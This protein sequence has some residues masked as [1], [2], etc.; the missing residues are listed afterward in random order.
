MSFATG[1]NFAAELFLKL[2]FPKML[3]FNKETDYESITI[4]INYVCFKKKPV[5]IGGSVKRHN[6]GFRGRK[7]PQ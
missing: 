5:P 3:G 4:N 2:N 1:V 7:T 6:Y